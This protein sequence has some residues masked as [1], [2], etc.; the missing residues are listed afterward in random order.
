MIDVVSRLCLSLWLVFGLAGSARAAPVHVALP[1]HLTAGAVIPVAESPLEGVNEILH[2]EPPR[3]LF[4][5]AGIIAGAV[6]ISPNLGVSEL[7]GVILGVIG[8]EYVY[9]TIY[10]P[11]FK[12]SHWF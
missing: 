11:A 12:P 7:F 1:A 2:M 4:L 8:S 10:E 3:L 9:Q 5:G 6:I